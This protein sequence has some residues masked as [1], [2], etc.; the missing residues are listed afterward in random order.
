MQQAARKYSTTTTTTTTKSKKEKKKE[1][2]KKVYNL[3]TILHNVLCVCVCVCV[4][5]KTT[6]LLEDI[7]CNNKKT[8]VYV[9]MRLNNYRKVKLLVLRILYA[10]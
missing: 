6:Q 2:E 8:C 4:H 1:R 3:M 5:L 10:T 7:H 9:K